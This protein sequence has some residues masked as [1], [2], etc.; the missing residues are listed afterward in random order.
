[1]F[2]I[3]HNYKQLVPRVVRINYSYINHQHC[4]T[5]FELRNKKGAPL[6]CPLR[7]LP[8]N[9]FCVSEPEQVQTLCSISSLHL[10]SL[11]YHQ[12]HHFQIQFPYLFH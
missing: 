11:C 4:I 8:V 2:H 5:S 12:N 1:M 10:H 7:E 9:I 6:S 3:L